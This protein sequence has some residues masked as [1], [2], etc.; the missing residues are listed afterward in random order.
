[1]EWPKPSKVS[2]NTDPHKDIMMLAVLFSTPFLIIPRMEFDFSTAAAHWVFSEIS[3]RTP[4]CLSSMHISKVLLPWCVPLCT[5]TELCHSV[6][7]ATS[8]ERFY[9]SSWLSLVFHILD[10]PQIWPFHYPLTLDPL[11]VSLKV[12]IPVQNSICSVQ[13]ILLYLK[14]S[15]TKLTLWVHLRL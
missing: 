10:N 2:S 5:Y 3:T 12:R 11:W 8:W 6:V 14:S 15:H 13:T 1:M 9:W 7:H 4:E